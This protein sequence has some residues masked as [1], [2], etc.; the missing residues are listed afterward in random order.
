MRRWESA[1]MSS[2]S[3]Q[4]PA[5]SWLSVAE[6]VVAMKGHCAERNGL[7]L[8]GNACVNVNSTLLH[9]LLLNKCL[10]IGTQKETNLGLRESPR[11]HVPSGWMRHPK[12]WGPHS[13]LSLKVRW[14]T[15]CIT[16]CPCLLLLVKWSILSVRACCT[17]GACA[18]SFNPCGLVM[19]D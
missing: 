6:V 11:A 8:L 3:H 2:A 15:T 5:R 4:P 18:S 9:L 17:K 14:R 12:S 13:G 16:N 10:E 7:G 19:E 1:C